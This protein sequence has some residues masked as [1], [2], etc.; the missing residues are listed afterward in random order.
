MPVR[1]VFIVHGVGSQPKGEVLTAVVEPW[2]QFLG[3][4]LGVDNVRL[5]AEIRPGDGPAHATITFGD[6]RW[7]IWEAHWA[8]SF[9]PLKSFRVLRWGFSILRRQ[10]G[11]IFSGINQFSKAQPYPHHSPFVYKRR[12]IGWTAWLADKLVSYPA[13]LLFVPLY[14]LSLVVASVFFVL[15]QLPVGLFQPRLGAVVTKLTEALVQ[16]PGDMAAILLSE[17][18]LA[19]M[20]NELKQLMLNKVASAS[21]NRPVPERAT[22]IA[23]SAGATVAFAALSD[24]SLWEVWDR[25]STGPKNISFLT[26]G[27]SLNLAWRSDHNHPIWQHSLDP[28]VR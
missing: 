25:A 16:G 14:F 15:S 5:E 3:K 8:Q 12:P 17:T 21:V 7:E 11:S 27:S 23:H 28:R 10:T 4:H 19:S 13:V 24:P 2:A 6:E 26:V 1:P 18:R 20:K 22:V 9:H